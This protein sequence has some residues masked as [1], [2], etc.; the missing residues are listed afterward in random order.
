MSAGMHPRRDVYYWK[1]DRPAAFSGVSPIAAE[2]PRPGVELM[3]REAIG[4][5]FHAEP[6]SLRPG[7]GQGNHLTFQFS[8]GDRRYFVRI[9]DGPERDDYL[10]VESRLLTEVAALGVPVPRASHV[11]ASRRDVPFAWQ[12]LEF[13]PHPDFNRL[14]K[15]GLLQPA[16]VA[17]EIGACVARWQSLKPGGFGPFQTDVLETTG[18]LQGYHAGYR[19]Y[20]F[21][22]LDR[23]LA[24]LARNDFLSSGAVDEIRREIGRCE[25]LLVLAQGCLVHKDLAFWNLLGTPDRVMAVIDWDDAIAGDPLDDLS[26]LGCFHDAAT[27]RE[28]FSGYASVRP[29]PGDYRSRYWL[30]LLRNMVVK[31]VI[32]VGAGYFNRT[33]GFFLIGAGGTGAD[34]R[35]FTLDRIA[36]A[37][38][39]LREN[40]DPTVP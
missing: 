29:L 5:T 32:R 34:L 4:R 12:V 8:L 15:D 13:V 6:E 24:F 7:A 17:R 9:E 26:L 1:S 40:S 35:K 19:N 33:D 38:R 39:G 36:L 11:D 23:H 28:A 37:L 30:H 10:V 14:Q 16:R 25:D 2:N 20:F 3:L 31:S 18:R 27:L 22:H 21:L